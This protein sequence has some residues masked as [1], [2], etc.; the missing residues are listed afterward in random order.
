[1]G[2]ASKGGGVVAASCRDP[3]ADA[4]QAAD[5][6]TAAGTGGSKGRCEAHAKIE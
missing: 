3:V 5:S 1:M 6:A 4:V 2:G